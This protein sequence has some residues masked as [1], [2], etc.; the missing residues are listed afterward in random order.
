MDRFEAMEAQFS[1]RTPFTS[2]VQ[3]FSKAEFKDRITRIIA[4]RKRV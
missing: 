4:E 2:H 3:Q 1:N